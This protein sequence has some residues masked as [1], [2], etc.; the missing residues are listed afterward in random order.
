[1]PV[2]TPVILSIYIKHSFII[3]NTFYKNKLTDE[4]GLGK[5]IQAFILKK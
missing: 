2:R 4:K 1:M 3:S 5:H